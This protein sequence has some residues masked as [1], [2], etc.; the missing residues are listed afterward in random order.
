M[1][2]VLLKFISHWW[3]GNIIKAIST[4]II[5]MQC[6]F[7]A[8]KNQ[9]RKVVHQMSPTFLLGNGEFISLLNISDDILLAS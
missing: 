5:R 1:V 6:G 4:A 9:Q 7:S 8:T 3:F 2:L